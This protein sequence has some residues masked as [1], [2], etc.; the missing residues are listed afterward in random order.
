MVFSADSV[1]A[2]EC[3]FSGRYSCAQFA[4]KPNKAVWER[5]DK[6]AI[7]GKAD[8]IVRP[9]AGWATCVCCGPQ[10]TS[11]VGSRSASARTT[12]CFD[13]KVSTE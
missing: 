6:L 2:G 5:A 8:A 13:A 1:L 12:D 10:G 7:I 3:L 11:S 4:G 9:V